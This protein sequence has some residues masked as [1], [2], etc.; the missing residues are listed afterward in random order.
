MGLSAEAPPDG[1]PPPETMSAV[2]PASGESTGPVGGPPDEGACGA[3]ASGATAAPPCWAD[4][5]SAASSAA[6]LPADEAPAPPA[7]CGAGTRNGVTWPR[8][9]ARVAACAPFPDP[10]RG[11][12]AAP[13]PA[14]FAGCQG[15]EI[16]DPPAAGSDAGESVSQSP[17]SPA[18]DRTSA[19]AVPSTA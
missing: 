8:T 19:A 18:A 10:P 15:V 4:P 17:S 5:P 12:M 16:P 14:V 7:C 9:S 13:P 1:L 11:A 6:E 2:P 3:K